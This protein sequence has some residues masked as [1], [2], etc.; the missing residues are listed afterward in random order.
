MEGW[1][2]CIISVQNWRNSQPGAAAMRPKALVR[3]SVAADFDL[4]AVSPISSTSAKA[5][6]Y[7]P[8]RCAGLD[9]GH[10]SPS[11]TNRQRW[12]QNLT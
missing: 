1:S 3:I 11:D 9:C 10:S 5:G 4:C 12:N 7:C 6:E 2:F 8:V